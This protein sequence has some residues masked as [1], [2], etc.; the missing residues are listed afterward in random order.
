M[1]KNC[2]RCTRSSKRLRSV[3]KRSFTKKYRTR[4]GPP[5]P[6]NKPGCKNTIKLGNNGK[7]YVSAKKSN[8]VF[9]WK[10]LN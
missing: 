7:R 9:A 6:A 8:G 10:L 4:P 1:R 2:S 5:F 3:C